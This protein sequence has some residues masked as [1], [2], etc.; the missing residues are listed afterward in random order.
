LLSGTSSQALH[1]RRSLLQRLFGFMQGRLALGLSRSQVAESW[2]I[3]DL[4]TALKDQLC[5]KYLR[6]REGRYGILLLVHQT[7]R[8]KGWH[9]GVGAMMTFD[10]VVKHLRAMAVAIAAS[11]S[12]A[13]QAEIAV[14]DVSNFNEREAANSGEGRA[15]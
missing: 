2:T 10:Q 4:E 12:N 7:P 15:A 14:L 13:P 5:D 8:P 11:S 1:E 6:A 9:A 3:H